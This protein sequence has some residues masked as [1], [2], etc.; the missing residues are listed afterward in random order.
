MRKASDKIMAGLDEARVSRR[1]QRDGFK[2]REVGV[3]E[4][5]V[6]AV[7]G[8]TGLSQP[9]FRKSIGVPLGT[10]SGGAPSALR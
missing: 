1:P 6:A 3:P 4:S 9:T 2:V 10:L 5:A 8:K 7:R